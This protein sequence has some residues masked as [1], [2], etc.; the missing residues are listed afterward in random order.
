M[1][2][3]EVKAKIISLLED[4]IRVHKSIKVNMETF[5]NYILQTRETS[6]VKAF[7]S[8]NRIIDESLDISDIYKDF[9]D[10]MTSQTSEFEE[11]DSGW[12]IEEILY[13]EVNVNKNSPLC[14]SSY[15]KLPKFVENKKA[16]P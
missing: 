2:F 9:V 1:F 4:I 16:V 5:A 15:I 10:T 7:N 12:A 11:K 14:G 3:D 13:V 6:D 8:C